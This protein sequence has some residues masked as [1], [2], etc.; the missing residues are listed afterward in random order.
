M[1]QDGYTSVH[2]LGFPLQG[3]CNIVRTRVCGCGW[4]GM[5]WIASFCG[6]EVLDVM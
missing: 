5:D 6:I 4:S 2:A 1:E 3:V